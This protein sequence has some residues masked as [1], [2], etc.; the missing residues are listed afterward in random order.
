MVVYEKIFGKYLEA[1]INNQYICFKNNTAQLLETLEFFQ[2]TKGWLW[3][4]QIF[5][6]EVVLT[7]CFVGNLWI[8]EASLSKLENFQYSLAL[9]NLKY[10]CAV[11]FFERNVLVIYLC[12]QIFSHRQP[13]N[14]RQNLL[15]YSQKAEFTKLP[16][17]C[18]CNARVIY[19]HMIY[20]QSKNPLKMED[21]DHNFTMGGH[22]NFSSNLTLTWNFDFDNPFDP[23]YMK[24]IFSILYGLVFAACFVGKWC[25][26]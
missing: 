8:S 24:V 26:F 17:G 9:P 5:Q 15:I 12:F 21:Y 13:L 1:K 16:S 4:L 25:Y 18:H 6:Q 11:L 22:S 23:I 19:V 14:L 10:N 3:Y 20:F 7:M 2:Y